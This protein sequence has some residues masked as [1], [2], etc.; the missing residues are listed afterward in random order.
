MPPPTATAHPRVSEVPRSP[1]AVS[2]SKVQLQLQM[3]STAGQLGAGT[4]AG[5]PDRSH[6]D[7]SHALIRAASIHPLP[8]PS[9]GAPGGTYAELEPWT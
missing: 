5:G 8:L 7:S 1:Q 2:T 3:A 6:S 4:A 9:M